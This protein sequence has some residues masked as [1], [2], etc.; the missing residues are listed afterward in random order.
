MHLQWSGDCGA[1]SSI[2]ARLA[3]PAIKEVLIV[4]VAIGLVAAGGGGSVNYVLA[5][6]SIGTSQTAVEQVGFALGQFRDESGRAIQMR[7]GEVDIT[8]EFDDGTEFAFTVSP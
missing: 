6:S 2:G 7:N 5:G 4:F 1:N 3:M 8:L